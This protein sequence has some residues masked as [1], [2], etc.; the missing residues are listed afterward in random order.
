MDVIGFTRVLPA[1]GL[2]AQ[3]A[4]PATSE[5]NFQFNLSGAPGSSYVIQIS[6]NLLTWLPLSTNTLPASGSVSI[7]NAFAN[8]S[9]RFYRAMLK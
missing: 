8:N 2:A 3:L 5:G 4:A 1:T 6:S 7:T 9:S